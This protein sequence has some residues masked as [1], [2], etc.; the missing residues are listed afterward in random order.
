M[1]LV[2]IIECTF[3]MVIFVSKAEFFFQGPTI[4]DLILLFKSDPFV[5]FIFLL[6]IRVAHNSKHW[7]SISAYTLLLSLYLTSDHFLH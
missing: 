4:L 1:A 3:R 6:H 5:T 2:K 7:K